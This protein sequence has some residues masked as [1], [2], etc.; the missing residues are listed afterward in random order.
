MRKPEILAP[1][2]NLEKLKTAIDYGADAVYLGGSRLNLRAFADNFTNEEI[3]EG[4]KYAHDRGRKVYVTMNVYPHNSDLIG[5]EDYLRELYKLNVD[6]IL[7]ADPSIL[8]IAK[9]VVPNLEI[10]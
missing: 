5:I 2:G 6:A 1:A 8:V 7:V 9:E 10:Q 3:A 4:V